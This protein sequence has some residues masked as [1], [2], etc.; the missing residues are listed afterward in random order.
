MRLT[1]DTDARALVVED[2]DIVRRYD[3]Y[4]PEA[5]R[6]ISRHWLR[7]GFSQRH[8]YRYTWLGRPVIQL[9]DDLMRIQETIVAVQ[10]DVI[11]E[12]GVAHGGSL[13][14]HASVCLALGRGRVIG[15]DVDIRPHNRAA[16]ERHRLKPYITLIEGNS[17][18]PAVLQQLE[19]LISPGERVMVILDSDHSYA[20]VSEELRLYSKLVSPGSYLIVADGLTRDLWDVPGGRPEWRYENPAQAAIDFAARCPEFVLESP[21]WPFDESTLA[22]SPTYFQS[23]WLKRRLPG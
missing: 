23:G 8:V 5:F 2:G 22:E 11:V 14:F 21:S 20:H 15:I 12:T 16:I 18:A 10:P 17:T 7:V 19:S 4:T 3:L 6:E 1:I 13:V 9:P